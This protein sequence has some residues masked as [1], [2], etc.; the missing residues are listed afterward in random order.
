M[1]T[2]PNLILRLDFR[3]GGFHCPYQAFG[4]FGACSFNFSYTTRL[5]IHAIVQRKA[6]YRTRGSDIP[7]SVRPTGSPG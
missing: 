1:F 7:H 2:S 4:A 3:N 5:R 6:I